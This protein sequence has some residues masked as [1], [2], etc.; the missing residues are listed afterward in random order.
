MATTDYLDELDAEVVETTGGLVR[1]ESLERVE[2]RNR[3]LKL[4]RQGFTHDAISEVLAKGED[5]GEPFEIDAKGVSKAIAR[6]VAELN[7]ESEED[8]EVLRRIDTERLETMFR[9]LELDA[10]SDD[11]A[12]RR[13]AILAQLKILERLSKLH[14]LDAPT[15]VDVR[16][17][18]EHRLVADSARVREV[19]DSYARRHGTTIALPRARQVE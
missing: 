17:G 8:A 14:G 12:T 13:K 4:R 15:K 19:D 11:E 16:G 7:D 5:G 2:R 6:Y 18:I 9:R 1:S 3:I 10:R